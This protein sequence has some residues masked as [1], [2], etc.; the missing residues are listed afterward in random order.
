MWG[1]LYFWIE[2]DNGDFDNGSHGSFF[3]SAGA[4]IRQLALVMFPRPSWFMYRA[5]VE[6]WARIW[7]LRDVPIMRG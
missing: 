7:R 2:L 5:R 6:T 1:N 4:L 3:P